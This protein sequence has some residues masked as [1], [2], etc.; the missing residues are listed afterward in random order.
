MR[1]DDR[2]DL[3]SDDNV[4]TDA[5]EEWVEIDGKDGRDVDNVCGVE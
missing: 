3:G 4:D 2:A 1:R 5:G